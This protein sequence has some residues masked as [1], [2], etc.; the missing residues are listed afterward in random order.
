MQSN[1]CDPSYGAQRTDTSAMHS[2]N[3]SMPQR[4]LNDFL[5]VIGHRFNLRDLRARTCPGAG[6]TL[7]NGDAVYFRANGTVDTFDLY[8]RIDL[9][10]V[11]R[12]RSDLTQSILKNCFS[13][14]TYPP[15]L[16]VPEPGENLMFGLLGV[17]YDAVREN[18]SHRVEVCFVEYRKLVEFLRNEVH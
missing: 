18:D 4:R 5:D 17:E 8:F 11:M 15:T 9:P 14:D 16:F 13:R 12:R 6:V 3:G 2:W 1:F 10:P 7:E